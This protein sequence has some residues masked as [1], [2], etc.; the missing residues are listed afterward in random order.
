VRGFRPSANALFRGMANEHG[1][2]AL[3]LILTGMGDD[4]VEGLESL[5]VAGGLTFA[6]GPAT[7][8]VFGMPREA[9]ERGAATEALELEEIAP[10]L[11]R[12]VQRARLDRP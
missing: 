9:L 5:R 6:Q 2:Q 3:G 11:V 10:R 7:S 4:G 1:A 8:V 12:H